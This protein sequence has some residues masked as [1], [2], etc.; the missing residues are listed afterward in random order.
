[1]LALRERRHRKCEGEREAEREGDEGDGE[2]NYAQNQRA[3]LHTS[4]ADL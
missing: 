2:S 4:S 3:G 1:M